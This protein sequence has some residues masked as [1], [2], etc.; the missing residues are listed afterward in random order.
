MLRYLAVIPLLLATLTAQARGPEK[1]EFVTGGGFM[2]ASLGRS[3]E[4]ALDVDQLDPAAPEGS[5]SADFFSFPAHHVMTMESV[6]I[7]SIEVVRKQGLVAGTAIFVDVISGDRSEAPFSVVFED[8]PSRQKDD[9][10][11]LTLFLDSGTET[12]SGSLFSGDVEVG[13]RK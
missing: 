6:S 3:V 4:F 10:M 9:T 8:V 5:M 12:Y 13:E 7:D 11:M 1:T 2:F